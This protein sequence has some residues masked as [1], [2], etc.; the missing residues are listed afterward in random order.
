[1]DSEPK[2]EA[3]SSPLRVGRAIERFSQDTLGRKQFGRS[4]AE[5]I[6]RHDGRE[7]LAIAIDAP[8]GE[9]KTSLKNMVVDLLEQECSDRVLT[10]TFT[11]WEWASQNQVAEAFFSEIAKQLVIKDPS[12]E[13][14]D[15]ADRLRTLGRYLG[16]AGQIVSPAG[17]LVEP[18]L[19]G[20]SL[21]AVALGKG[22]KKAKEMAVSASEEM[23]KASD[24][25]KKSLPKIKEEIRASLNRYIME[26]KKLIVV[27]IDDL[28]RLTPEEI[29]L[30][31]Q[32][33]RVNGDFPGLVFFLLYDESYVVKALEKYFGDDSRRF[34]EKIVQFQLGL[35]V[36]LENQLRDHIL[37]ELKDIC[38]R[39][40][41][42]ESLLNTDR[43]ISVW[44]QGLHKYLNNLRHSN[45]LLSSFQFHLGV[46][47]SEEAEVNPIDFFVLEVIRLFEP[48]VFRSI[49]NS[50]EQLFP[51][52]ETAMIFGP[53]EKHGEQD[54]WDKVLNEM[55]ANAIE[56]DAALLLIKALFPSCQARNAPYGLTVD[57][58]K[59]AGARRICHILYFS[60]YFRLTIDEDDIP[61]QRISDLLR[62]FDEPNQFI[63]ELKSLGTSGK[64]SLAMTKLLSRDALP[65]SKN[66][67]EMIA[68]LCDF[69][70]TLNDS[71]APAHHLRPAGAIQELIELQLPSTLTSAGRFT[72]LSEAMLRG[73]AVHIP[74]QIARAEDH[75]EHRWSSANARERKE[76]GPHLDRPEVTKLNELVAER[77][78]GRFRKGDIECSQVWVN[79][80]LWYLNFQ[81]R[82]AQKNVGLL[83]ANPVAVELLLHAM[84]D[85]Q[86]LDGY[87]HFSDR[88][89]QS[90]LSELQTM[91]GLDEF[92]AALGKYRDA[93]D[94][95]GED[96]AKRL[97]IYRDMRKNFSHL[98]QKLKLPEDTQ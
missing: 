1:M 16:L 37:S 19:P 98:A 26:Q 88:F 38:A 51:I 85:G 68:A 60:R 11:P 57:S 84:I 31:F 7:S 76:I 14:R 30:V 61:D 67:V 39:R 59:L 24:L 17:L 54:P 91:I 21:V 97:T 64:F 10:L 13:A 56:K 36:A 63:T 78:E 44:D 27:V 95:S 28:D 34:L 47:K 69:G 80:L 87:G 29:R 73:I 94:K 71:A 89:A 45:R 25:A 75:A 66:P 93:L 49:Q 22:L 55:V 92:D 42:Y 58:Q 70:E 5:A 52:W 4:L 6:A 74:V 18:V 77:I 53:K 41:A 86:V 79:S 9:G 81:T 40:P 72:R 62:L 20:S 46:F 35:P 12:E 15:A 2:I 48:K 83:V 32:M 90:K 23:E 82:R 96:T 43:F 8:W 3:T 65:A 50:A 33:I